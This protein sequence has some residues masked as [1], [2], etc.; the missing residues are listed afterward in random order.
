MS[1]G[2]VFQNASFPLWFNDIEYHNLVTPADF[3]PLVTAAAHDVG[4]YIRNGFAVK[5]ATANVGHIYAVTLAQYLANHKSVTGIV[6]R[7]I[8]LDGYDWCLTPIVKVF[9]TVA[10][11]ASTVTA[12]NVGIIF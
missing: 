5:N 8:D 12:I 3:D 6:P 7:R 9:D 1:I 10:P 2:G 4:L 11:Y